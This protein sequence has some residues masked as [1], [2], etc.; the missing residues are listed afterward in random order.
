MVA[1]C[2]LAGAGAALW[3][4]N[5]R[6][7][8]ATYL[9]FVQHPRSA[10]PSIAI[11]NL[12]GTGVRT[13]GPGTGALISPDGTDVAVVDDLPG[14]AGSTLFLYPVG[15]GAPRQLYHSKAFINLI[16]WSADSELLLADAPTGLKEAG[17]LLTINA[18]SGAAQTI[19]NGVL[20]GASFSEAGTDDVVYALSASLQLTAKVNLFTSSPAG[21]ETEQLTHDGHSIDPLW[22]PAGI[23]FA[24]FRMRGGEKFPINQLWSINADGSGAKQ[25][26]HMSVGSLSQGLSPVAFSANGK[27]LLAVYGGEDQSAAW[28]VDLS[29][30]TAVVHNLGRHYFENTPEGISRDGTMVLLSAGFEG[31]P[32]AVEIA[33]WDGGKPT[34]VIKGAA[35]A[36]WNE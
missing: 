25:L 11:A 26:T 2:V 27:H 10:T 23:V 21:G 31:T 30:P 16:G 3:V 5:A 18:A 34:V 1:L 24:R 14:N 17:P 15:G 9:T 7:A 22:G 20:E 6:A 4:N 13:L 28:T 29:G 12:D 8:G 36:S 33:P 32:A 19:A 35:G